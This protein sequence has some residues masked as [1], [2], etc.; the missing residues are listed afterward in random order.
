MREERN[1]RGFGSPQRLEV[2]FYAQADFIFIDFNSI[3]VQK[4]E[5]IN[6]D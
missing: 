2:F 5:S 1:E 4:C 6:S 3:A